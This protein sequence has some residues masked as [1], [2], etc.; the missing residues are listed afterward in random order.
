MTKFIA[1]VRVGHM[2]L[3]L[4]VFV[5]PYFKCTTPMV[6]KSE[7]ISKCCTNMEC[8]RYNHQDVTVSKF[9]TECGLP[10]GSMEI[11][12]PQA[13]I[14][15]GMVYEALG[16]W[17]VLSHLPF[18]TT[19][20]KNEKIHIWLGNAWKTKPPRD[21]TVTNDEDSM[22]ELDETSISAEKK[23]LV[24]RFLTEYNTLKSLYGMDHV[25]VCW[26]IITYWR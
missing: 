18:D 19:S 4:H 24:E 7:E 20:K 23:L 1:R 10:I 25:K 13:K 8:P 2:G 3:D 21:F 5:G 26:G 22:I 11:A 15:T 9:C 16:D 14:T 17:D 12:V 6:E